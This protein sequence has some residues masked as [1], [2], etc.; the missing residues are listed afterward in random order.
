MTRQEYLR[1]FTEVYCNKLFENIVGY[2][3]AKDHG[4]HRGLIDGLLEIRSHLLQEEGG[5]ISKQTVYLSAKGY[6][7]LLNKTPPNPRG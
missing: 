3:L 2:L 1:I 6:T 7:Y 5:G 4:N